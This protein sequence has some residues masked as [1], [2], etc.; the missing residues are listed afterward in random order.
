MK[1]RKNKS[2][3][4]TL[5]LT[6]C[7]PVVLI[8]VLGAVSYTI[9]S[10]IILKKVEE[11]SK[12]TILAVSK[13]C[14]LLTGNMEA[15]AL[16]LV[17]SD[18]F[19]SYYETYYK[20][21]DSKSMQYFRNIG[22]NLLRVH[23]SINYLYSYTIIP[24]NGIFLSSTSGGLKENAYEEFMDTA[25]GRYF[26]ENDSAKSGWFGYHTYLD[27]QLGISEEDYGLTFIQKFIKA[28]TFLVFDITED[29]IAE[30]LHTMNFGDNSIKALI[31]PDDH[32]TVYTQREEAGTSEFIKEKV[33]PV[34]VD[35]D[36]YIASK[37]AEEAGEEYVTYEGKTYLYVYA[38]VGDTGIMLCGLIPQSNIVK[39]VSFIRDISIFMVIIG[40]LTAFTIGSVIAM[41]MSRSA[42]AIARGLEA[43]SKGNLKQEFRTKRKDEFR[44]LSDSLNYTLTGI[45]T[46]VCEIRKFGKEVREMAGEV[47]I[48]SETINASVMEI[49]LAV[50]EV[51]VGAEKQAH[52]TESS[53]NKMNDFAEK[54]DSVCTRAS[55]MNRIIDE[56]TE[57]VR[58]G[59][60]IMDELNQKTMIAIK[61]IRTLVCNV[62][63]AEQ[64]TTCIESFLETINNI[65]EQTSL[66]SLNASIEAARAGESGKGFK[67]V[68]EEIL[69]LADQSMQA[70]KSI[71]D[72]VENITGTTK[73]MT[74]STKEADTIIF[75]QAGSSEE[76]IRIFG[77]ISECVKELV[78]GLTNIAESMKEINSEKEQ[79]QKSI[80]NI[81]I[82]SEQSA[83][84]TEEVT[85]ALADSAKVLADLTSEIELLRNETDVLEQSMKIFVV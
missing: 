78:E 27:E 55:D 54:I 7:V 56:T 12:S 35:K 68:A 83:S 19:S 13:Y 49:L 5:I 65:A 72:I 58:Q 26:E 53:N 77:K 80:S 47:S 30:V 11:S 32:E 31:S 57:A 64:Q 79:V 39:E 74:E 42:K 52:E 50:E 28:D 20:K 40:C 29:T 9:A 2:I 18:D 1:T 69:K 67:I 75:A 6:F 22:E 62:N 3:M 84:V 82:V 81:S 37:T 43:V 24:K 8:I 48:K 14:E 38:P 44:L 45:R 66:L 71:S 15:K 41:G 61:I 76:T 73:K 16:E 60:V 4:G 10:D 85:A 25:E 46:I 63:A 23:A 33:S 17:V 51:A 70:G 36:F 59:Q 21:N 34:F